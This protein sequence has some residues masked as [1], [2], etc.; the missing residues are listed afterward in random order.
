[1][2]F[3]YIKN[4]RFCNVL[5]RHGAKTEVFAIRIVRAIAAAVQEHHDIAVSHI[6]VRAALARSPDVA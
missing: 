3:Q 4:H 1:M 5:R 6:T 2:L